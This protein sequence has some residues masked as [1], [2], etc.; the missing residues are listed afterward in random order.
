MNK[1]REGFLKK[2]VAVYESL[3]LQEIAVEYSIEIYL[4]IKKST[5]Y[6]RPHYQRLYTSIWIVFLDYSIQ[7]KM[8]N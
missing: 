1:G 6:G 5:H 7:V 8:R 2:N 4:L 3:V